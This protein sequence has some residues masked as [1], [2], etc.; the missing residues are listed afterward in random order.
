VLPNKRSV[1]GKVELLQGKKQYILTPI[2]SR[3]AAL[4]ILPSSLTPKIHLKMA[5]HYFL[6]EYVG[7]SMKSEYPE[8]RLVE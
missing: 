4:N 7:W 1:V 6:A 8:C 2:N 5:T 3:I